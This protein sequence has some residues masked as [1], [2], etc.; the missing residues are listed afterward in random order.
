M[1][2]VHD[3]I[4]LLVMPALMRGNRSEGA[5]NVAGD[6]RAVR[7]R[8]AGVDEAAEGTRREST[9]APGWC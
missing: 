3:T 7:S 9:A 2:G 4:G 6:E 8:S 5:W 1:G